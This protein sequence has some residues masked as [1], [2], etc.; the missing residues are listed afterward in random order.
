MDLETVHRDSSN[1]NCNSSSCAVG[2]SSDGVHTSSSSSSSSDD[3]RTEA[4][5]VVAM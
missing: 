4:A 2:F 5:A 1:S 3:E